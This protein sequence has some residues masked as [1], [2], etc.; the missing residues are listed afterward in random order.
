[1]NTAKIRQPQPA[2]GVKPVSLL[3]SLFTPSLFER[4]LDRKKVTAKLNTA[5]STLCDHISGRKN[6]TFERSLEYAACAA[7]EGNILP[8]LL[9]CGK[10]HTVIP[11]IEDFFLNGSV[12]DEIAEIVQF[13]GKAK[14]NFDKGNVALSSKYL[15]EGMKECMQFEQEILKKATR[16]N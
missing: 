13:L 9:A 15:Q 2:P 1:M 11:K 3:R 6:P 4:T 8:A 12:D 16:K 5:Y 14:E 10:T 7:D